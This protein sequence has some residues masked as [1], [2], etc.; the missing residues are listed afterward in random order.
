MLVLSFS[1]GATHL[2]RSLH[3]WQDI[4]L[5]CACLVND[6]TRDAFIDLDSGKQ[7]Q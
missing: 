6:S 3:R 4:W 5:V 1:S 7:K 2:F